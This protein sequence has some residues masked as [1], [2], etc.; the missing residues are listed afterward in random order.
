MSLKKTWTDK[1][2][3][4]RWGQPLTQ[5]KRAH[6]GP[7]DIHSPQQRAGVQGRASTSPHFS[8]VVFPTTKPPWKPQGLIKSKIHRKYSWLTSGSSDF[9]ARYHTA[10]LCNLSPKPFNKHMQ[11][12]LSI[13]ILQTSKLRLRDG[14]KYAHGVTAGRSR[15]GIRVQDFLTPWPA[16]NLNP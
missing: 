14:K 8:A 3:C 16:L 10:E 7:Q 6:Q 9:H 11:Y 5:V 1:K 15:M 12:W 13:P 4:P 2:R